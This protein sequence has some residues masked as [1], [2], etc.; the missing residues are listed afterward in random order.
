MFERV[1]ASGC[2][3]CSGGKSERIREVGGKWRAELE[4]RARNRMRKREP[5]CVQKMPVRRKP[6]QPPP[7]AAAVCVV[8]DHRMPG[9]SKMDANLV[10]PAREKVRTEEID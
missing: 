5:R 4:L 6:R 8:P 9:R 7:T 3:V 10:R 2:G 1:R